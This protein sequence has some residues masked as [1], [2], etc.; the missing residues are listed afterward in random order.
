MSLLSLT[1]A[2]EKRSA[3]MRK[4]TAVPMVGEEKEEIGPLVKRP[5]LDRFP[6]QL[7]DFLDSGCF[8]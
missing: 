3:K 4:V 7:S 8:L 1:A 2:P 5:T 6:F